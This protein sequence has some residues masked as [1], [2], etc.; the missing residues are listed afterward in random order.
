MSEVFFSVGSNIQ[1]ELNIKKVMDFFIAEEKFYNIKFSSFYYSKPQG[2]VSDNDF[3]NIMVYC[4]T[5]VDEFEALK[6]VQGFEQKLNRVRD[7]L[8]GYIDRTIDV[9][10]IFFDEKIMDNKILT[11]PH[12][13]W[14]ERDFV[15]APLKNLIKNNQN[16]I[17]M[18]RWLKDL[19]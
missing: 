7:P 17:R 8:R 9:D 14:K 5:E 4:Q 15:V 16:D 6:I 10:I 19:Y 11:L 12:P 18:N 2:F 3:I 1:P 13:R